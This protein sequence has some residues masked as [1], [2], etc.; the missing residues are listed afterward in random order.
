MT[1][2]DSGENS[3]RR[4][5][6]LERQLAEAK[7]ARQQPS[8][9]PSDVGGLEERA[10]RFAEG[11]QNNLQT[12]AA[13]APGGPSASEM[14][15][16]REAFS[17]AAA[18]A[19]MSQ[20]QLDD[21]LQHATVTYKTG[22][23]V[24]YSGRAE[25]VGFVAPT[26]A[27][28]STSFPS[29]NFSANRLGGILGG[30]AG[31]LGVIGG[32]AA[33]LTAV[34]PTSALW[35]S[36]IVCGGPNELM[37][38]TSHY[39]SRPGNSSTSVNFQCLAADGGHDASWFAITS[40][41]AVM[42]ALVAAG[43]VA[44]GLLIRRRADNQ[45]VSGSNRLVAG[46]LGLASLAIV[47]AVGWQTFTSGSRP[48]QMPAGGSLTVDGN[49]QTKTIACNGGHLTVD[50]REMTVNVVGHCGRI[51]VDGVIHHVTVDSVDAIDV[52]GINNV[53][54]YHTGSPQVSTSGGKNTVQQG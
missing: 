33:S 27:P 31:A 34:L 38:N 21:A 17:R 16:L 8:Q 1:N 37:V 10:R 52:D 3:E 41:Q 39:S 4:I 2:F 49:A 48:V 32:G 24:S 5:A 50:G 19:G 53:V 30:A 11:L 14:A 54:I 43:V 25:P 28:S 36:A 46:L 18:E 29:R 7:A 35:T 22:H 26:G 45:P 9:P 44:V 51:S 12:G 13:G 15:G 40:L 20:S 47:V 23:A 6:E 42:I